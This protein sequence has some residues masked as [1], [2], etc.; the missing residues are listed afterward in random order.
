LPRYILYRIPIARIG[1]WERLKKS[2][3]I[4]ARETERLDVRHFTN[5]FLAALDHKSL[6]PIAN[7]I[8]KFRKTTGRLRS[9]YDTAPPD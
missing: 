5:R 8:K 9:R 3:E 4:G 2:Q 1:F 6:S 7:A